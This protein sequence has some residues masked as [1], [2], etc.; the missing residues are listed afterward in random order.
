M[1]TYLIYK[2][3]IASSRQIKRYNMFIQCYVKVDITLEIPLMVPHVTGRKSP[4][5]VA[6]KLGSQLHWSL[7]FLLLKTYSHAW[8]NVEYAQS[9]N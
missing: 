5:F 3:L 8:C 6:E 9:F 7:M 1:E 2:Q 4:S